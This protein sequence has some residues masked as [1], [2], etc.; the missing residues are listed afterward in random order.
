MHVAVSWMDAGYQIL[1]RMMLFKRAH[2]QLDEDDRRHQVLQHILRD[3]SIDGLNAANDYLKEKN[4]V[5]LP[6]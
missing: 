2:I 3:Q 4:L 5:P 1:N 6:L